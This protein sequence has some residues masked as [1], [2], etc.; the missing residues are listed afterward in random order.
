MEL[1]LKGIVTGFILSIMIGPVF[2]VL[3]ETSI[4]KGIKAA[5]ALD[6]GVLVNDVVYVLVRTCPVGAS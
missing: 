2:F 1:I 5:I 6:L 3:L 4:T